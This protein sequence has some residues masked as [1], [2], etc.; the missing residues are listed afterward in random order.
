MH[1]GHGNS[2]S[3]VISYVEIPPGRHTVTLRILLYSVVYGRFLGFNYMGSM[4]VT[5]CDCYV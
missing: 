4:D 3:V 5:L 2:I 1:Y